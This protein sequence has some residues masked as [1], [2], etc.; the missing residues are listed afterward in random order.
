MQAVLEI[1]DSLLLKSGDLGL[2]KLANVVVF[3]FRFEN[4]PLRLVS[5]NEDDVSIFAGRHKERHTDISDLVEREAQA[6]CRYPALGPVLLMSLL[7]PQKVVLCG[8][9]RVIHSNAR[10]ESSLS[11][12]QKGFISHIAHTTLK[13]RKSL[14]LTELINRAY[15]STVAMIVVQSSSD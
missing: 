2:D 1:V 10:L 14:T 8:L 12:D 3:V 15:S 4:S 6:L 5:K 13:A 9:P 11:N 7:R